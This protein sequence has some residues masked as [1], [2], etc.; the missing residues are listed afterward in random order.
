MNRYCLVSTPQGVFGFVARD[1]KLV[2]SY[3]PDMRTR[4]RQRL[5]EY[6]PD[7]CEDKQLLPNFQREVVAYYRGEVVRFSVRIDLADFP[8]FHRLVLEQCR[9]IPFGK[10]ASY[11]DLA[12]AAGR[13]GA[14]RAVGSAMA[15][16]PMPLV[17]P[18]H[19]VLRA[20]GSIGGFSSPRGVLQKEAMLR[21]EAAGLAES[22]SRP[23]R[24]R[25]GVA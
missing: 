2:A 4:V 22:I 13:A 10:T 1:E 14:A 16:N 8:P 3:L 24:R 20:D 11:G 21:F 19:R 25:R 18:C 17:V 15:R 5:A 23:S 6:F 7:A 9:K 12:R